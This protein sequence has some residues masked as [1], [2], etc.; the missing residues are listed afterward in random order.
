MPASEPWTAAQQAAV[1]Q[2][3]PLATPHA[4]DWWPQTVAWAVLAAL[5]CLGALWASYRAWRHWRAQAYRR[6]ALRQW[7][8]IRHACANEVSREAA[9]R[10]LPA[11]L[12]RTALARWPRQ[13]V[14]GLQGDAWLA[15]LERSTSAQRLVFAQGPG[16]HV[17]TLAYVPAAQLPWHDLPQVL[18][19]V[20]RWIRCHRYVE[21][22]A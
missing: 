2:L 18:D 16:R 20:E 8:Q 5:L 6:E 14:A 7:R 10:A 13:T 17:L 21:V 4:P 1:A 11:L 9:A 19:L 12:R 22:A 3:H 15:F